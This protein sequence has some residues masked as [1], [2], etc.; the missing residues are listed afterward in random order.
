[1]VVWYIPVMRAEREGEQ[2][3]AVRKALAKRV[4]S[5][6]RRSRFG[7]ARAVWPKWGKVPPMSSSTI[8]RM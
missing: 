5:R 4:P 6:A 2:T 1:M 8:Q 7:V 3:E